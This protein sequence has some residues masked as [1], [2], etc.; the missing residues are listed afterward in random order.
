MI[1]F[2][3]QLKRVPVGIHE[4]RIKTKG[5]NSWKRGKN[6]REEAKIR[7]KKGDFNSKKRRGK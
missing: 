7:T 4:H 2:D 6:G 5:K 1:K 3:V